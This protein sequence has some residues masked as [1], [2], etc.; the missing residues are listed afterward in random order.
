MNKYWKW[1]IPAGVV[2]VMVVFFIVAYSS[3]VN[4]PAA[5]WIVGGLELALIG[6]YV[7]SLLKKDKV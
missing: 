1:I 5:P 7:L 3:R 4:S 2:V 6:I